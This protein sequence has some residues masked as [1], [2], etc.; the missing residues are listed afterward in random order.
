MEI[1]KLDVPFVSEIY[2]V[3]ELESY[4]GAKDSKIIPSARIVPVAP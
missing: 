4:L 2:R 1:A 3:L